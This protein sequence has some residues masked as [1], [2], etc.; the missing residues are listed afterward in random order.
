MGLDKGYDE[1]HDLRAEFGFTA[2]LRAR[3]EEAHALTPEAGF[4]ARRW[5]VERTPSWMNRRRRLLIRGEKQPENYLG[6]LHLCLAY[7][8]FAQTSLVG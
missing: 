2:P 6:L 5:V 1:V 3:G 4:K 7:I 8:T